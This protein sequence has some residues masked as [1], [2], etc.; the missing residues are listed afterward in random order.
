MILLFFVILQFT[1]YKC[2]CCACILCKYTVYRVDNFQI[3]TDGV[4][5]R[6]A[7]SLEMKVYQ[8]LPWG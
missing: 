8:G 2:F 5:G 7:A 3:T 4:S 1:P 6:A